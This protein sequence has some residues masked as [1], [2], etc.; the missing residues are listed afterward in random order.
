MHPHRHP[1]HPCPQGCSPQRL[2]LRG[3]WRYDMEKGY[4]QS[5]WLG[6]DPGKLVET[7]MA[8]AQLHLPS[9]WNCLSEGE[10]GAM[11]AGR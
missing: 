7:G 1:C 11:P 5:G 8:G 3:S 2:G 6:R 10:L 9:C 4:G